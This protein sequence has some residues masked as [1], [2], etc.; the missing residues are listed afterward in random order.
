MLTFDLK[1]G[2]L[3]KNSM[4]F[5]LLGFK[6]N[7]L[8]LIGLIVLLLLSLLLINFLMSR[9][10]GRRKLESVPEAPLFSI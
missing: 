1:L 3:L 5:A 2:K 8:A 7:I 10:E 9:D 6:R 4:I